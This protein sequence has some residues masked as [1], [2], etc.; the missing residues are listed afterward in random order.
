LQILE[1]IIKYKI[2]NQI[3]FFKFHQTLIIYK[4]NINYIIILINKY[5]NFQVRLFIKK[6]YLIII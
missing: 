3:I 6:H 1:Y 5:I 2:N 4:K